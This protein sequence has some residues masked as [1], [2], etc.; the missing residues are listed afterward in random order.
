MI[1][2]VDILDGEETAELLDQAARPGALANLCG[3]TP[4]FFETLRIKIKKTFRF[5][6]FCRLV[7]LQPAQPGG[8]KVSM[9]DLI[10]LG[11]VLV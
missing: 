3:H 9:A 8:K 6:S 1:G 5:C 11:A 10:V 7:L 2:L 4:P